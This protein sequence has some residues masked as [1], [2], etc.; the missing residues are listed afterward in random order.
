MT[1]KPA[2]AWRAS[3]PTIGSSS[4]RSS[5]QS[6]MASGP[7]SMPMRT[8]SGARRRT[9]AAMASGSVAVTPSASV[10]PSSSTTQIAVVFCETSSPT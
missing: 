1:F 5:F 9:N 2:L 8:A 10:L 4:A 7:V 3:M 6:Q